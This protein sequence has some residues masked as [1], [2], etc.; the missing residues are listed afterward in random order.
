MSGTV[1][2]TE[3]VNQAPNAAFS[4]SCTDLDCNFTDQSTDSD[5]SIASW[6]WDFDDGATSTSQN[7]SNSYASA[8]TYSVGLRPGLRPDN[9]LG[10]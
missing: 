8:G 6:S 5:G 4:S 10:M 9:T 1:N 3:A 2:I 7:P